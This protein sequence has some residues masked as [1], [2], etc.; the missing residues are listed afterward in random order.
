MTKYF[1]SFL[2]QNRSVP[3]CSSHLNTAFQV[4]TLPPDVGRGYSAVYEWEGHASIYITDHY[5]HQDM[6]YLLPVENCFTIQE[7][8]E[9]FSEGHVHCVPPRVG[10]QLLH[11]MGGEGFYQYTI[12]K[13]TPAKLI[14]IQFMP[15]YFDVYLRNISPGEA[16]R[17]RTEIS[18]LPNHV[19]FPEV[20]H[21]FHQ[22]R[23]FRGGPVCSTL[24]YRS[25]INEVLVMLV[26]GGSIL[27]SASH[28]SAADYDL[29]LKTISYLNQQ[30][31]THIPLT[32]L[33]RQSCMSPTKFKSTLRAVVGYPLSKYLHHKRL[34]YA[35]KLLGETDL[36]ISAIAEKVG[37]KNAG[38]F[39]VQFKKTL[40]ILPSE[41]RQ[42]K[43]AEAQGKRSFF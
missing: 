20:S 28:V 14:G 43:A 1:S 38:S 15:D 16:M 7:Y 29:I 4:Y 26:K 30:L 25:K 22:I 12:K 17:I 2:E 40:G 6:T 35:C 3:L 13:D 9:T 19:W 34:M 11:T 36:Q 42:Q 23:N 31:D 8:D 18:R 24:Y 10:M 39:S 33:A 21:I 41:Y 5:Y 32:E 27:Q 37:Y